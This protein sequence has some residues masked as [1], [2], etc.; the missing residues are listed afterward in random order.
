MDEG[1]GGSASPFDK[2]GLR[3]I[4]LE[5][6]QSAECQIPPAQSSALIVQHTVLVYEEDDRLWI[7]RPT[8]HHHSSTFTR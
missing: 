2:G 4:F 5:A 3:G 8:V 6:T 7:A 1:Y